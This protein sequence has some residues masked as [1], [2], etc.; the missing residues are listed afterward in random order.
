MNITKFK[1]LLQVFLLVCVGSVLCSCQIND[2]L[3]EQSKQQEK[4]PQQLL[5]EQTIDD[6][7]DAFLVDTGGKLGILLITVEVVG[8]REDDS[9]RQKT[10]FSVW[11]PKKMEQPIQTFIKKTMMGVALEHHNVADANFD[12]VQDFVYLIDRGNQPNYWHYWLWNEKQTKFIYCESLRDIS[13]PQFKI[14]KK[15]V[16]GWNRDSAS[17]GVHTF[18][19]WIDGELTLLR[20]IEIHGPTKEGMQIGTVSDLTDGQMI[21]VYRN[22]WVWNGETFELDSKWYDLDYHGESE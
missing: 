22:E 15:V 19:R 9:G 18:Y 17:S 10:I 1:T 6:S 21:E 14:E 8:K 3:S 2:E 7:H 12:G 11:N 5:K 16:T 13:D 20:K 4:S